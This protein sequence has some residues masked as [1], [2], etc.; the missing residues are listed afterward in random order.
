MRIALLNPN[1]SVFV[2]DRM[3]T[4]AQEIAPP[5]ASIVGYTA[6]TGPAIVGTRAENAV[7]AAN[8][9]EMGCALGEA[10]DAVVLGISTD[11]GLRPLREVLQV[12]VVGVL[13][14]GVL[15]ACQ[16]GERIGLLTLGSRMLPLY[17]EQVCAYGLV[18]KMHGW[19]APDI[20]AAYRQ[21]VED[22]VH[23]AIAEHA[24]RLA[25]ES[26]LDVILVAGAVL[27]GC[28]PWLERRVP[29]PVVDSLEAAIHQAVGLAA[30]R[31]P[32]PAV[33][34]FSK[35]GVRKVT[36]GFPALNAMLG[37]PQV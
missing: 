37:S 14:A 25:H 8:A 13:Q 24:V 22:S 36:G 29:V 33:G 1:T 23:D 34:S 11:A 4:A 21:D 9:L 35:P 28:R 18:A 30:S 3:V 12:P 19:A 27:A 6:A 7:A 31:Y 2:T 5:G 10:T 26:N 15:T 17:Q 32:K 16:L 20:A